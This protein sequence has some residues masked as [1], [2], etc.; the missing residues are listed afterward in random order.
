M[1]TSY[2]H[3]T[4]MF[5]ECIRIIYCTFYCMR[6]KKFSIFLQNFTFLNFV[7]YLLLFLNIF[8]Y[9]VDPLNNW[10]DYCC[11]CTSCT[12]IFFADFLVEMC[13]GFLSHWPGCVVDEGI[14]EEGAVYKE[15]TH[16]APHIDVLV[17]FLRIFCDI[18]CGFSFALTWMRS[19]RGHTRGGRWI[20]KR[21]TPRS[22]H[23]CTR[24]FFAVFLGAF[25]RIFFALTWMR[26]WRGHTRG[27]RWIQRRYTLRSTHRCTRIFFAD[28]LRKWLRISF[29]T[30]LDA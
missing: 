20:R 27:G 5:T 24:I 8:Q 23:R 28:F 13:C 29:R 1:R 19:W 30:D 17:F 10:R 9:I 7:Q 15:D 16:S 21:R 26:S 2:V 11:K 6:Q 25:L 22:T 12:R 18:C 4:R 3:C 14:P